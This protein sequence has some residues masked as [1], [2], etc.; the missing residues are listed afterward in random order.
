MNKIN[1]IFR[2]NAFL[3]GLL[4]Q[5]PTF[6]VFMQ[7]ILSISEMSFCFG[8]QPFLT[9]VFELPTGALADLIGR[10]NTIAIGKFLKSISFIIFAFAPNLLWFIIGIFI[11]SLGEASISGADTALVYDTT[12]ENN[13]IKRFPE[14]KAKRHIFWSSA[15]IF[16]TAIGGYMY[17]WHFRLPF[18]AISFFL[19]SNFKNFSSS[20]FYQIL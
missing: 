16:A 11:T 9:L 4:F 14:I 3:S 7:R 1:I 13:E 15:Y 8:L 10:K 20:S 17:K 2:F 6:V 12:K 5:L 18:I 19:K